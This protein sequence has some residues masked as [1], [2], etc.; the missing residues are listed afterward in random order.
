VAPFVDEHSFATML[1]IQ[2]ALNLNSILQ[3]YKGPLQQ[4]ITFFIFDLFFKKD[5]D[6]KYLIFTNR[7]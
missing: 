1:T 5:K 6:M 7:I 3:R 4:C 2:Y